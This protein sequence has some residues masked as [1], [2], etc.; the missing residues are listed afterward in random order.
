MKTKIEDFLMRLNTE[1]DVLNLIDIDN[2]DFNNAFNSIMEM[3]EDNSG[4]NVDVIY[5]S[6]AMDFLQKN[7][8]SL[9]D[10][11]A[12]ASEFGYSIEDLNSE[13]LATLLYSSMIREEFCELEDEI[14][15]FFSELTE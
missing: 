13:L 5:Y 7:D 3:I 10:S 1:I 11:I 12:L 6:R 15:E 4:F 9:M 2:I 14:N 8:C